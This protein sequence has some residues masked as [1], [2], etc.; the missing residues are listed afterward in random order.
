MLPLQKTRVAVPKQLSAISRSDR[1]KLLSVDGPEDLLVQVWVTSQEEVHERLRSDSD[2]RPKK[3]PRSRKEASGDSHLS[4]SMCGRVLAIDSVLLQVGKQILP[5][6]SGWRSGADM[7]MVWCSVL[8]LAGQSGKPGRVD[9][10]PVTY[11]LGE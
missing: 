9:A 8:T 6:Y 2:P 3:E 4:G 1:L 7:R 5:T 10:S 11:P